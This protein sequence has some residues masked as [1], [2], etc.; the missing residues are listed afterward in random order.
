MAEVVSRGRGKAVGH[1]APGSTRDLRLARAVVAHRR[2]FAL[3]GMREG[4]GQQGREEMAAG[5]GRCI[6]ARL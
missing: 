4:F 3:V 5:G 2:Q 1:R 6:E